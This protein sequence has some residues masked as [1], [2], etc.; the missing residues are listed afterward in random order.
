MTATLHIQMLGDFRLALDD[1][2]VT[3]V[4]V[5]RAQSLLAY[6]ALH[7]AAP[8]PRAHLAFLLW[9][10]S[11]EAQAHTN[12]RQ[13]VF[14]LRRSLPGADRYLRTDKQTAQW[15]PSH[16]EAPWTLDTLDLETAVA[17][18][19]QAEQAGDTTALR[20]ALER[21]VRLYRGDLLPGCYDEWMLGERD[22]LRTVFLLAAEQLASLLEAERDY[23]AAIHAAHRLLR[24]D[25]LHEATYRR[26]MRLYALQGDRA[27]ALRIYHTCT[28]VLERELGT[29]PSAATQAIHDTLLRS[30]STTSAA[31]PSAGRRPSST[32]SATAPLLGRTAEWRQLQS[33]WR[34]CAGAEGGSPQVVVVSGEAGIGKTRLAEEMA[35]WVSRQGITTASARCYAA[36][37][38]LAYAPVTAWLR[39]TAIQAGFSTLES[40][41]LT[42]VARLTPEV[43]AQRPKLP[44]PAAMTEGWQRQRFF[45]ALVRATLHARQPILLL[46]DDMQWCDDE[47]L[48]WLR[49]LLRFDASA[50]LLVIGTVRAGEAPISRS[51]EQLLGAWRRDGVVTEIALE[52]LTASE[53]TALAQHI[54]GHPLT[55]TQGDALYAETEGNPLFVVELARAASQGSADTAPTENGVLHHQTTRPTSVPASASASTLPPAIQSV[56]A[57]RVAQLSPQARTVAN[58]AAVIGRAFAFPLVSEACGEDE[59][60]VARGLDELWQ[61][62]L[63]REQEV[64][65]DETYDF[66]HDKLRE[67]LYTSLSPATR[68]L[69]HR[70]IARAC[71]AIYAEQL[72]TISGQIAFHYERA[73]QPARAIPFYQRAGAAASH[74]YAHAEAIRAFARAAE[75]LDAQQ[76]RQGDQPDAAQREI[77]AQIQESLG[78]VLTLTGRY[79]EAHDAYARALTCA[80][81][82][83]YL[84]QA[85]LYRKTGNTWNQSSSNPYDTFH[86]DSAVRPAFQAALRILSDHADPSQPAWRAEWIALHFAQIWPL[87]WSADDMTVTI[88]RVQPVVEQYG[89]SEQREFLA[90]AVA[91]RNFIQSRYVTS[92]LEQARF[93]ARHRMIAALAQSGNSTQLALYQLAFGV[94]L[95]FAHQL[96]DAEEQLTQALHI[97]EQTGNARLQTNCLTFLP[98]VYRW[99]GNVERVRRLLAQAEALGATRNNRILSGQRAWVAWRAGDLAEAERAGRES[100]ADWQRPNAFHWTGGWPLIGLALADQQTDQHIAEAIAYARLLLDPAQ[101]PQPDELAQPLTAALAAWDAGRPDDA[102]TLLRQ[103]LPLATGLGYL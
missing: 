55:N 22:R 39:A 86:F 65:T 8:Q 51:L 16:A 62:R 32:R 15:A 33:I 81:P 90:Y 75:L 58:T 91:T 85:R 98:F 103:T 97:G 77:T 41:W 48:A 6:L 3:T 56:L 26:L 54:T 7:S 36:E 84:Q 2:P 10:D 88:D 100:L 80:A 46:L 17:Q 30:E 94:A 28:T 44:R 49:Y 74:I 37:G 45:E 67:Y 50:R 19:G 92:P 29:E 52:P 11:T 31:T 89:T 59:D 71:E 102:I 83:T 38:R 23:A 66:A 13:A 42:E 21:S 70:R 35:A 9:P 61:R 12:L 76:E 99:H 69:L 79:Q 5:P 96:D 4:T 34:A 68:R 87:S 95:L 20:Q 78:D 72:D 57:D 53:T 63:V 47:T 60:T 14:Q 93:P 40:T 1:A 24:Q 64:K 101:N 25:T 73:G 18:A 82:E 43:M 27:A